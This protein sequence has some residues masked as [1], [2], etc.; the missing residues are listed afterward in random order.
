LVVLGESTCPDCRVGGRPHIDG[1]AGASQRVS[2]AETAAAKRL[3][4]ATDTAFVEAHTTG[5]EGYHRSLMA[6][7][8][9]DLCAVAGLPKAARERLAR[10]RA[11]A[12]NVLSFSCMRLNQ[13]TVGMWKNNCLINLHVLTAPN[14]KPG[15]GPFS[16]SSRPNATGGRESRRLA[17]QLPGDRL[18]KSRTPH[19]P[20]GRIRV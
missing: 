3:R 20:P 6:Q 19:P 2:G 18:T 9:G 16:L 4:E 12:G 10:L 15:A 14:G 7:D 11:G 13:G 5:H 8:P 17:H 1:A